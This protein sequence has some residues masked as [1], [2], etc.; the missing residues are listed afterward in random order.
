MRGSDS[1]QLERQGA[2]STHERVRAS[3]GLRRL[4][5][6]WGCVFL[7]YVP[8][9]HGRETPRQG[10]GRVR[11]GV[12]SPEHAHA[13]GLEP[14]RGRCAGVSPCIRHAPQV[15]VSE[16][17]AAPSRSPCRPT[18]HP[19]LCPVHSEGRAQSLGSQTPTHR[20]Q[21]R[22]VFLGFPA[23][24]S[25]HPG[26]RAACSLGWGHWRRGSGG[27]RAHAGSREERRQRK[28]NAERMFSRQTPALSVPR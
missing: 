6:A 21:G 28:E 23:T 4:E 17:T 2:P 25:T 8:G 13:C 26:G 16:T 12:S 27:R 9:E 11:R 19:R 1:E 24:G 15:Q 3:R 5:S 22:G 14:G 10:R 20:G 18:G 7:G